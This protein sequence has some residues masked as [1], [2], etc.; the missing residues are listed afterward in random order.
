M[1]GISDQAPV[2]NT[3][4]LD[5]MVAQTSSA[6]SQVTAGNELCNDAPTRV[7]KF[8]SAL[9]LGPPQSNGLHTAYPGMPAFG[10]KYVT[11]WNGWKVTRSAFQRIFYNIRIRIHVRRYCNSDDE[12]HVHTFV[13][14]F[15]R[16]IAAE[17]TRVPV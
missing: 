13:L 12:P 11:V 7:V 4:R 1:G 6:G 2:K 9:F 14:S 17:K 16:S 15:V 10:G 8:I 3:C 5:A